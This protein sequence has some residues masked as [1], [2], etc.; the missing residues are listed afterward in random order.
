[1][2]L[3]DL[4]DSQPFLDTVTDVLD[5]RGG[6]GKDSSRHLH[7][8]GVPSAAWGAIAGAVQRRAGETLLLVAPNTELA[9]RCAHDLN[10]LND[11]DNDAPQVLLF[12]VPD[13]SQTG[14]GGGD[15]RATQE[16]LGVLD[17]LHRSD[18]PLVVVAPV[19]AL[20]H[21]TLPPEE[22]RG[23]YDKIAVGQTLDLS[24]IHI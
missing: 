3:L 23:G 20:A 4:F 12:P 17:A 6:E 24:L 22:L 16:R 15:S 5:A 1:M 21:S 18:K 7:M 8:T 2:Q 9:E 14:S 19:N 10:A 13:R 11:G